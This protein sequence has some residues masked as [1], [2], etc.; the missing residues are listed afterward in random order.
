MRLR[1]TI[2]SALWLALPCLM[3]LPLGAAD[4]KTDEKLDA[5]EP[6]GVVQARGLKKTTTGY[7]LPAENDFNKLF[8]DARTLQRKVFDATK[9]LDQANALETERRATIVQLVQERRKMRGMLQNTRDAASVSAE[10][11]ELLADYLA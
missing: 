1:K 2:I 11:R 9:Q 5:K 10:L 4:D 7:L 6:A 8:K 3:V